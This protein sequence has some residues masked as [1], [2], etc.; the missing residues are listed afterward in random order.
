M[1]KEVMRVCLA[2]FQDIA[3]LANIYMYLDVE[4]LVS[5]HLAKSESKYQMISKLLDL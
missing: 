3:P 1:V 2:D 4:L 5:W